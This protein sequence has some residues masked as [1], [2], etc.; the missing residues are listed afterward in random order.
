MVETQ[1]L[2]SFQISFKV[3]WVAI[4]W[5]EILNNFVIVLY[6]FKHVFFLL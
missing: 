5:D 1:K 4:F 6:D 2:I 3:Y